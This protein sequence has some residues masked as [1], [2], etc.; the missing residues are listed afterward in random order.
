MILTSLPEPEQVLIDLRDVTDAIWEG[1][2]A[3]VQH[4]REYFDSRGLE[5]DSFLAA[6]LTRFV[7]RGL[8]EQ[9]QHEA[10]FERREL[11]NSGLRILAVRNGRSYDLRIR[12]SDDGLLPTPQSDAMQSFYYQPILA[13]IE[14]TQPEAINLVILWES[15][16]NYSHITALNIACPQA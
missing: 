10:E 13:G 1:L 14:L 2:E 4:A 11:S 3:G 16:K 7:A 6:H 5:P 9:N 15:P 12:K 8:L